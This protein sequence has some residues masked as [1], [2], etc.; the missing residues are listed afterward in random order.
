MGACAGRAAGARKGHGG[1]SLACAALQASLARVLPSYIQA[2][3]GERERPVV[4][5]V[6]EALTGVLR[7]CGTLTLQSP[8]RLIDLCNVLKAVLQHKVSRTSSYGW[9]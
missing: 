2:V 5:T 4:M 7:T 6:L 9:A 3:S 8:G 1:S